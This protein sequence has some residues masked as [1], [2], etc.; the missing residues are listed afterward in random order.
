MHGA[1]RYQSSFVLKVIG[2]FADAACPL[3]RQRFEIRRTVFLFGPNRRHTAKLPAACRDRP[4]NPLGRPEPGGTNYLG[5][6]GA[7]DALYRSGQ[8]VHSGAFLGQII[9][10]VIGALDNALGMAQHPLADMWQDAG[11][12]H[13]GLGGAAQ[14]VKGPMLSG[15]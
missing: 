13:Q 3:W 2:T 4:A 8:L 1:V 12:H 14:I 6:F 11:L 9:I 10:R 5:R 15:R 7:Q